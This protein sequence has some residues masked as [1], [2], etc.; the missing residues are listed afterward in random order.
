METV[1]L[2]RQ[3]YAEALLEWSQNGCKGDAPAEED[4]VDIYDPLHGI[5]ES[6]EDA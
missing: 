4:Y 1:E 3:A 2:D 5:D 6:G